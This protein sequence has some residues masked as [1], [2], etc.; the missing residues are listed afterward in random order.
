MATAAT[1]RA[2]NAPARGRGA[3]RWN[4][5]RYSS[6][7]AAT[8]RPRSRRR[9]YADQQTEAWQR[10]PSSHRVE[11]EEMFQGRPTTSP[12]NTATTRPVSAPVAA[13]S[14]TT[15]CERVARS[16]IPR[17]AVSATQLVASRPSQGPG[18][19]GDS[20]AASANAARAATAG[21]R[22]AAGIRPTMRAISARR[23]SVTRDDPLPPA[24]QADRRFTP[25]A[26]DCA[27]RTSFG[28]QPVAQASRSRR[29]HADASASCRPVADRDCEHD[30]RP[31]LRQSH[32]GVDRCQRPCR[33]G[34]Q[35]PRGDEQ[36]LGHRIV[37]GAIRRC[38]TCT[39]QTLQTA[40]ICPPGRRGPGRRNRAERAE[41]ASLG[42]RHT[43]DPP[44]A[45]RPERTRTRTKEDS[46]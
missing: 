31:V 33:D 7:V 19:F 8:P 26:A 2:A 15:W 29:M 11:L 12:S 24:G 21:R 30:E 43:S 45:W 14:T 5:C 28:D 36:C 3:R 9:A 39:L 6:A 20:P 40:H 44:A 23:M 17:A 35:C 25:V 18:L 4:A 41:C 22:S 16:R 13:A 38:H 32:L 34:H 37:V 42:S 10:S 27:R 1:I 46:A